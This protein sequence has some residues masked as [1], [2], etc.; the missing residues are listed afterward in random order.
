MQLYSY[1]ICGRERE[2]ERAGSFA[3]VCTH[4]DETTLYFETWCLI[5][6]ETHPASASPV[7]EPEGH[8][9]TSVLDVGVGGA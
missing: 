1:T 4:I 2:K 6:P 9:V 3:C 8:A 5:E 7:P